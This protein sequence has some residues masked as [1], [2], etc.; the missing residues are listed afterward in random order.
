M[1][2]PATDNSGQTAEEKTAAQAYIEKM[3]NIS[4]H[5]AQEKATSDAAFASA[6]PHLVGKPE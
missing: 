1:A 2:T 5:I 4:T 6:N 3:Q